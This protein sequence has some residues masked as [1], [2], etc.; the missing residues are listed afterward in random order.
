MGCKDLFK[1]LLQL[2]EPDSFELQ[3]PTHSKRNG[4]A[5]SLRPKSLSAQDLQQQGKV[6]TQRHIPGICSQLDADQHCLESQ[7]YH[8]CA[9]T[10]IFLCSMTYFYSIL[11]NF[12]LFSE[13]M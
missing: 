1:C 9:L 2:S 12:T 10:Q 4:R 3:P 8:L 5:V 11:L 7:A 6:I 13:P